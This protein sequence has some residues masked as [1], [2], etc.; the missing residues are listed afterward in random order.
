MLIEKKEF[1]FAI[2]TIAVIAAAIAYEK[3]RKYLE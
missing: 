1:V 2:A 3:L